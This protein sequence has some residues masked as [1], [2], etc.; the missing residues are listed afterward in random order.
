MAMKAP[1]TRPL[2]D[3]RAVALVL[4]LGLAFFSWYLLTTK[5]EYRYLPKGDALTYSLMTIQMGTPGKVAEDIPAMYSR[6][7]FPAFVAHVFMYPYKLRRRDA[8]SRVTTTRDLIQES[9]MEINREV[10]SAWRLSNFAAYLFQLFFLFRILSFL[11]TDRK[12]ICFLL[13]IYSTW[14]LSVRLYVNWAQMPDPWAFAFLAAAAYFM[15]RRSAA[16]FFVSV[17]L[18]SLCKEMLLF[19]LP[20]FLWISL[21]SERPRSFLLKSVPIALA[22]VGLF[23]LM[24]AYPYFPSKVSLPNMH[25][26]G[27]GAVVQGGN[28]LGDYL[29]LVY[30]HTVYR[31]HNDPRYLLDTLLIPTGAFTALSFLLIRHFRQALGLLWK[32]AWWIPYVVLTSLIGLN[33]DRYVFYLFP[34]VII[35]SAEILERNYKGRRLLYVM[36]LLG[37]ITVWGQGF[38]SVPSDMADLTLRHQL[39]ISAL[40]RPDLAALFRTTV[41]ET[42]AAAF[43]GFLAIS[44]FS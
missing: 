23:F 41:L 2:N 43:A 32:H 35:L 38:M 4:A 13:A 25:L 15:L 44:E 40:V 17:V 24:R 5:S 29:D 42:A 36:A 11:R 27:E 21:R 6:R 30:Y 3:Y 1:I 9:S 22:P 12:I 19:T 28:W 20:S 16:G 26:L 31:V 8:L 33:V 37:L 7:L 14:F 39:E 34:V 18:G 10:L